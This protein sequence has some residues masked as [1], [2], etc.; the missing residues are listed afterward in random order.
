LPRECKRRRRAPW[1]RC[2]VSELNVY[3][4]LNNPILIT[5]Y[6]RRD[7]PI[8][9]A[10]L[11][12]VRVAEI[13]VVQNIQSF[14][15]ELSY[16]ALSK[17]EVFDAQGNVTASRQEMAGQSYTFG[18]GYNLAGQLVA[19][20]YPS[21]R[22]VSTSYDGANRALTVTG[23]LA[24]VSKTYVSEAMY[25]PHGALY[26]LFYGNQVVPVYTYNSRLQAAQLY[27][28]VG[29]NPNSYLQVLNYAWGSSN[30]N[31]TLQVT[32]SG[33][34]PG[35]AYNSL[36]WTTEWFGYDGVNRVASVQDSGGGSR[37]FAYDAYGNVAV[38]ANS[39]FGWNGQT[40]T[41]LTQFSGANQLTTTGYD[42]A[43]N[44]LGIPNV[45]ANCLSYDAENRQTSFLPGGTLYGYDGLG[46]RVEKVDGDGSTVYVYDAFGQLAAEY[47]TEAAVTAPCATC[48]LT[49]DALGSTRLVTD[50]NANVVARHDYLPFGEEI[51]AGYIGRSGEFG[52]NDTAEQKFTGQERDQESG[53]D[54]FNA[55][56]YGAA[57][58]RFLSPDPGNAGARI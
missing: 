23:R 2:P 38:P 1:A 5:G 39:G 30:N 51:T 36:W 55:R 44:Q 18:Y 25:W 29:N 20:T 16:E 40:P 15:P 6:E 26:A 24:G 3:S 52:L 31:G 4:Q 9:R 53:L 28:T 50:Q 32:S 33:F 58:G 46:Q 35:V 27:T 41:A 37:S 21:G 11:P 43:G 34:G 45:C 14:H 54:Y 42:A 8:S 10:A 57:L 48:Y 13:G 7:L 17:P 49:W 19:E 12:S 22:V 56:Y 47:T